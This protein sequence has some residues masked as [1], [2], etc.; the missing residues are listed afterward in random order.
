MRIKKLII[1]N[2]RG[3]EG[4]R[5]YE[6]P[7]IG[8]LCGPNGMGKSTVLEALRYAV[9]GVL[10]E[11]AIN[12]NATSAAV[13][14][15]VLD[16]AGNEYDITRAVSDKGNAWYLNG[17]KQT[18]KA[19]DEVIQHLTGI[20]TDRIKMVTSGEVIQNMST[21]ALGKLLLEYIPETISRDDI[22]RMFSDVT[23]GMHDI[24]SELPEKVVANDLDD[25][26]EKVKEDRRIAKRDAT[27]LKAII[28]SI[29]PDAPAVSEKELAD[30]LNKLYEAEGEYKVYLTKKAQYDKAVA[31]RERY[32]KMIADYQKECESIPD[33]KHDPAL[34]K[35]CQDTITFLTDNIAKQNGALANAQNV[36]AQL[37]NT[38]KALSTTVCPISKKIICHEDKSS[39]KAELAESIESSKKT[40]TE[41][42]DALAQANEKLTKCR[43]WLEKDNN[44]ALLLSRKAQLEEQIGRL[45]KNIPT[46]PDKPAVVA[47]VDTVE[48][49][50]RL[51]A[52][53]V[54]WDA[55]KRRKTAED[56]LVKKQQLVCDLDAVYKAIWDKG[57][58][59]KAVVA[60]YLGIFNDTI[61]GRCKKSGVSF[62][63]IPGN[64]GGI[65]LTGNFGKGNI[66]YA[67]MSSGERA[68][69][70]FMLMDMLS[71]LTGTRI[72]M[73]DD[74]D[75]CDGA[76]FKAL[77]DTI[78]AYA[79]DYDHILVAAVSH[80]DTVKTL[81]KYDK[82]VAA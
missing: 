75:V 73:V 42:L 48:E 58:V 80:E 53:R 8:V 56:D 20:P 63:F 72:L 40:V 82:I 27:S 66:P 76:Y 25:F 3:V 15:A 69:S 54:Q 49:K 74:A 62:E 70:T 57:P 31:D 33:V 34:T 7:H 35:R 37:E 45:S 4:T 59:K 2:F 36:T 18:A 60:R 41:L 12:K 17:T 52:I 51:D 5:V 21:D 14:I 79:S 50:K 19:L 11:G 61:N 67:A 71:Q 6:L 13:G 78:E 65:A 46:I 29:S 81:D 28:D 24:L 22:E 32:T 1:K 68:Y 38:L 16:D 77:M 47:K 44:N 55:Y 30:R 64:K 39:A 9:T 26:A 23:P 43:A 10:P